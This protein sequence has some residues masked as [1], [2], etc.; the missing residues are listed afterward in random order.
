MK[1]ISPTFK[2]AKL[3]AG[4]KHREKIIKIK[5]LLFKTNR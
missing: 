5:K 3:F 1:S 4:D 2:V